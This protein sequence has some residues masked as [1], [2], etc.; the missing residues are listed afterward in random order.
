MSF[1]VRTTSQAHLR[2]DLVLLA[3]LASLAGIL[4]AAAGIACL[5]ATVAAGLAGAGWHL[6]DLTHGAR[7]L[8]GL[9]TRPGDPATG[10][11]APWGPALTGRG[12]LVWTITLPLTALVVAAVVPTTV[13]CW[14]RLAPLP[15]GHA[16]RTEI[17]EELSERA[18]R[19]TAAWT[20][21][22]LSPHERARARLEDLAV[23][24]HRAPHGTPLWTPLE[25]PTGVLAPTQSGKSRQDLVHKV[26]AAPGALLCSTSKP[27]LLGFTALARARRGGPVLV[28]DATGTV[29]WPAPLRWPP[30]DGCTDPSVAWRRADT[31]VEAASL[32]L[33]QIGG[34]DKVFR[35][36]AKTVLQAY[37]LAAAHHRRTVT[38]LV[39]WAVLRDRE[40]VE[41][42]RDREPEL[43][44]NLA[45]EISMVAET[46]DAVWLSVRRVLEPFMDRHLRAMATPTHGGGVNLRTLIHQRG[47]IF[48][49][50]GE[51]QA[52]Q[53]APLL[54]ALTE[55]WLTTAQD[56]A[57]EHDPERL[58]P[59]ATAVL[60]E[61]CTATPVPRLPSIIADSAG[62]GVL[63]HYALQSLAQ[64]EDRYGR[65]GLRQLL[66][67]TTTLTVFGGLKDPSTL[68]WISTMAGQHERL[69]RHSHTSS[70]MTAGSTSISTETVPTY[71]PG[72]IR[73]LPRGR[74]LLLH[75][76]LRPI[77]A[78]T[79]DVAQRP[80]W[81]QLRADRLTLRRGETGLGPDGLLT[82]QLLMPDTTDP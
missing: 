27:D 55:Q 65:T 25:N 60:D 81:R 14:R 26:L 59:P 3:G 18:A 38:D 70:L 52:A 68:Q 2:D 49:I 69:R 36:R 17:T 75:R 9:A 78:R 82:T 50:A 23:P 64:A 6:P 12:L 43:A 37:L 44:R 53:A 29:T 42:L 41:L 15:P 7:L 8:W 56:L 39:N 10:L 74:V 35:G 76:H 71:R 62:R 67:N 11:P 22:G 54:T 40:P 51:H 33:Q 19:R 13:W 73:T 58:D 77:L 72:D 79:L 45:A 16:H 32:D 31:M 66:D 21:P 34:N 48:L 80:D 28:A 30:I 4:L 47:T 63:I 61:L 20:R 5:A 57:L 46:A 1:R 24:L